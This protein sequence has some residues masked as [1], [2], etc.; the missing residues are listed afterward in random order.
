MICLTGLGH[1]GTSVGSWPGREAQLLGLLQ[2][3]PVEEDEEEEGTEGF[4]AAGQR[5]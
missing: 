4:Q 3:A 1:E 2:P 5:L